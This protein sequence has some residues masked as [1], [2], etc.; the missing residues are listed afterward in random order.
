MPRIKA[1]LGGGSSEPSLKFYAESWLTRCLEVK[2][3]GRTAIPLFNFREMSD[4]I[5]R[6]FIATHGKVDSS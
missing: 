3:S 5:F 2:P 4:S 6:G 1:V